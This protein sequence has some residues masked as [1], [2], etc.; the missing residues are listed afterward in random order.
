MD[1]KS[2]ALSLRIPME[3]KRKLDAISEKEMRSVSNLIVKVLNDYA[4]H[5]SLS[6][7]G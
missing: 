2:H 7:N 6:S 3:L 1:Q 4:E 5:Y